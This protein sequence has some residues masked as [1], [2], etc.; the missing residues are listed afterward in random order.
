VRVRNEGE[1]E[2]GLEGERKTRMRGRGRNEGGSEK[3]VI[4]EI[5]R[6]DIKI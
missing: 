5:I 2:R 1:R 4:F 3:R 6:M